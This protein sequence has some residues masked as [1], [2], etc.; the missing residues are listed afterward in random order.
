M[1]AYKDEIFSSPKR[2]WFVTERENASSKG[3][4]YTVVV[5]YVMRCT[6]KDIS[7]P[8]VIWNLNLFFWPLKSASTIAI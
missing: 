1:I 7:V 5:V 6:F 3:D 4:F 2:T 8:V